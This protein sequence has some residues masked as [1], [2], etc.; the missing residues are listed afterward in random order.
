MWS[1]AEDIISSFSEVGVQSRVIDQALPLDLSFS[2]WFYK[3]LVGNRLAGILPECF[4]IRTV[5][6]VFNLF[7]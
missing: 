1:Q 4:R 3:S 7:D 6:W 2:F 5:L